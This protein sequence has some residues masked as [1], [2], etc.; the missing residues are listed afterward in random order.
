LGVL[1]VHDHACDPLF[2]NLR[3]NK[4]PGNPLLSP[5]FR[6]QVRR[7]F[8][9]VQRCRTAPHYV[10]KNADRNRAALKIQSEL[11]PNQLA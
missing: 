1:K 4:N 8:L 9:F 6:D 7:R 5:F 10:V 3:A 11:L 2:A